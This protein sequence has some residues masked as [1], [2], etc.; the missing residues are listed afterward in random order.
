MSEQRNTPELA[1][2]RLVAKQAR[3]QEGKRAVKDYE[4]EI[5]RVDEKT[6]RLRALRLAKEAASEP[7][8]AKAPVRKKASGTR[9]A[10]TAS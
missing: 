5:R 3:L 4:A 9:K 6:A 1:E 10:R 2:A 8:K 7:E